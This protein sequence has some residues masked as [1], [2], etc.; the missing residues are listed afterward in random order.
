MANKEE[1][2]KK[3]VDEANK[4][5][6]EQLNLVT[7][8]QDKMNDLLKVYRE[9][10]SLDKLSLDNIKAVTAATKSMKAEYDSVKDVQ[11]D[12]S[13]N[14]KLQNDIT[15][16]QNALIKKGG[17]ALQ[18]ELKMLKTKEESLAKAQNKL[19]KMESDKKLGKKIDAALY[20]QAADTV[21]KKGEQLRIANEILTPEAQQ[22]VMLEEAEKINGENNKHLEEQLRR[23]ENLAKS[24]GLFTTALT[25]T[26]KVL[27]KL[28]LG[29]LGKKL[30]LDA[31]SK[32]AKDLT[33]ELTDGGKKSLG[34]FGK[35]RVGIATFG[36]A[37]KTALGPLALI[38]MAT[39]LFGKFKEK[40][41]EAR[42]FMAEISQETANFTRELGFSA[43]NGAKVAGQARAIGGAM[44]FTHEQSVAAA[45]AI[46]G[47]IQ[48]T[49]QLG[50]ETM[51]TFMKLN[52]HG[53]VSGDVL[54]KIYN[55]S[56]LTGQEA[57]HVAEEIASQAQES[58][59]T[60]KVNVS[61]K[62]VME[63]VSKVSSRVALNF[64][65]SGTAITSAVVQAKKLGLEMGQVE[66]IANSLLNIEDSIAAEME[67]ELLTGKDLNLEKARAAAL[68]GDNATLME[69][70]ANQGITAADYASMNRIQQD[71][72]A[73]SLGMSGDG[74]ADMLS[75]QKK[76]EASNQET[77]PLQKDSIA[78]M[79]SMAS[80]AEAIRN[81][82]D[83][84][85]AS[86]G[87]IGAMYQQFE[88]AMNEIA[89]AL[90]PIL[91]TLFKELWN[92][93]WPLF[94]GVKE[95]LTD[96]GNVKVMTEGIKSAFEGVKEFVTP[97]FEML[98]QLAIDLVPVIYSI[99]DKTVGF[100]TGNGEFTTMEKIVGDIGI[101][102]IGIK[103]TMM[104][105][106]AYKKIMLAYDN[107]S[108]KLAA[109][110]L[111]IEKF[112]EKQYVKQGI[113]MVK[114]AAIQAKD[115]IKSIGSAIMKAISSL[116]SIP[117]VGFA[118]GIAAGATIAGLAAK[119]MND[120]VIPPSSGGGGERVMYG[121]E[122]AIKFNDKDTIVAGTDLFGGSK[123]G[124]SSGS[125]DGAVVAELQR[126]S[127]L[128]QQILSKEGGV[129]IDGNKVGATIALSNYQ[130]Q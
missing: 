26:Q 61:M 70:L 122:G 104:G 49:E 80:L 107:T 52:V 9:K 68:N 92:I 73:K 112:T 126:V 95:W 96:S 60:M 124:G 56:K 116:A 44:G 59:K 64:K 39:S 41:R 121:P 63:G 110:K 11:K 33:Y 127:S 69:E 129:Y 74:L 13:K 32:K 79:T 125:S 114:N 93:V 34:V 128:L 130:Q 99:A 118:L 8:L 17:S 53:G 1:I 27:D 12:I 115:F 105:I 72:L 30:G 123:K 47:Q 18:D 86:M 6:G 83:A 46:Y 15:S 7:A 29:N 103:A 100:A 54:G 23:Q 65:G 2:Q 67:A 42:D 43:S 108:K 90:M 45:G 37:L 51:K 14:T 5:L 21:T 66:D 55:I 109:A 101:A 22:L 81:E 57:G 120:G 28:G 16:Q 31:A 25:G 48:G 106:N 71:A 10:G 102:F 4:S 36:T 19:A 50:A 94:Q 84:K 24:Q 85:K 20:K 111:S 35:M 98:K 40:G 77:L 113:Q 82:E 38:G 78:A 119:Y 97:I 88:S 91:N 89:T 76:N 3:N 75:T 58:L 87:P 62:A 117:V